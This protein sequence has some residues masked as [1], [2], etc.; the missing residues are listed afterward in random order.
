M[1]A[2]NLYELTFHLIS[3]KH[4]FDG[5]VMDT[6][7]LGSIFF[8]KY[9]SIGMRMQTKELEDKLASFL[10]K[11]GDELHKNGLVIILVE[12]VRE[13]L[14]NENSFSSLNE[15]TRLFLCFPL[16]IL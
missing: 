16:K 3:S 8:T 1:N 5:L 2:S 10:I 9:S 11:L 15:V 12:P 13:I 7:Y 6:G 14:I 4:G